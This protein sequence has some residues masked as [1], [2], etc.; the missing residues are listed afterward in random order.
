MRIV[1]ISIGIFVIGDKLRANFSQ[2]FSSFPSNLI[3]SESTIVLL[4]SI[5]LISI[6]RRRK[7]LL[8]YTV[9]FNIWVT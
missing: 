9:F 1:L 6:N 2:A 7:K 8:L 5:F 3:V 4:R